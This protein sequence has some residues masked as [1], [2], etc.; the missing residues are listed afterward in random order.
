MICFIPFVFEF[1]CLYLHVVR[2]RQTV[3]SRVW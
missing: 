3:L 1:L 2:K